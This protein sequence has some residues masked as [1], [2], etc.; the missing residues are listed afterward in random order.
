MIEIPVQLGPRS[1]P[2]L[3]GAGA[4]AS[5]GS[6][7]AKRKVGRKVVLVSDAAI[8]GRG[9]GRY[10][11]VGV[12]T[13]VVFLHVRATRKVAVD[14]APAIPRWK[15]LLHPNTLLRGRLVHATSDAYFQAL[16]AAER[17]DV[18]F[19]DG[20]HR[21]AQTLRDIES[22]LDHLAAGGVV[23][24]HDCD[25]PSAAAASADPAAAGDGVIDNERLHSSASPTRAG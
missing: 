23:F 20:D 10:L 2:I 18:V 8:A 21:F 15:W 25:P 6:E 11:E 7:L 5:V 24:V 13:G 17:F 14:P 22:A 3:V 16:P 12:N 4:L 19:I 9:R 1:Y